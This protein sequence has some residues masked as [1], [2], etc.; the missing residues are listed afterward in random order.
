MKK[1]TIALTLIAFGGAALAHGG[2][3]NKDVMARMEVMKTIGDEMKVIGAMAKGEAQFD[4]EL[5][6]ATLIEIAAQSAQIK[7]MFETQATDPKSEALPNIWEDWETF[8]R[9][10]DETEAVA[11]RLAGTV[12]AA[13][14]IGPAMGQ[15]GAACKACHSVYRK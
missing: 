10:A 8:A 9:L 7:S 2:V 15:L 5:V 11:E 12:M 13:A 6:Q 4:A 3:Q 14:D 1:T